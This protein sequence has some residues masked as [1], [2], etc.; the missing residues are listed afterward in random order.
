MHKPDGGRSAMHKPRLR[1]CQLLAEAVS[2][3]C[4]FCG[5][6]QPNKDGSEM[7]TRGDFEYKTGVRACVSCDREVLIDYDPK[8]SFV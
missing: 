2:V 8:A 6:A 5:D 1:R 7:W 3:C 4:P